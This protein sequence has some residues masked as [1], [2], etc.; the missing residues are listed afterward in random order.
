MGRQADRQSGGRAD[1]RTARV[2]RKRARGSS[3]Q[4]GGQI[5]LKNQKVKRTS[6]K[7]NVKS[8]TRKGRKGGD[9]AKRRGGLGE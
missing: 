1:G 9:V 6:G 8:V 2:Q 4:V 7:I 3:W 5:A